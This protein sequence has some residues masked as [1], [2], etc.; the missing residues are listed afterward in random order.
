MKC[1][2]LSVDLRKIDLAGDCLAKVCQEHCHLALAISHDSDLCMFM[3]FL[4]LVSVS[5][6]FFFIIFEMYA[7][8]VILSI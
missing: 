4:C 3:L 6:Q 2:L 5:F 7:T 8:G 1:L